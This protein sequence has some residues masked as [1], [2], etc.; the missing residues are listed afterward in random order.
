MSMVP[1]KKA[2]SSMEMR[3]VVMSPDKDALLR[4]STRSLAWMS[5]ST[6]PCRITLRASTLAR[7]RP[8]GPIVRLWPRSAIEPST[9]PSTTKSSLPESSPLTTTDLPMVAIS[10]LRASLRTG[11]EGRKDALGVVAG[12]GVVGLGWFVGVTSSSLR[13]DFHITLGSVRRSQPGQRALGAR[14]RVRLNHCEE[15]TQPPAYPQTVS[16]AKLRNYRDFRGTPAPGESAST[17]GGHPSPTPTASFR[18]IAG[19]VTL[20]PK[21]KQIHWREMQDSYP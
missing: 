2:P 7:T 3:A 21:R 1:L 17:C 13:D 11:S 15:D 5:P 12:A 4:N 8:L 20:P 19:F 6:R 10:L 9:S 16:Q 14:R 18:I